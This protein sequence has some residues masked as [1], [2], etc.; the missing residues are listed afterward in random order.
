MAEK[1]VPTSD[2][3]AV[4][5]ATQGLWEE[6]RTGGCSSPAGRVSGEVAASF[7][8]SGESSAGVTGTSDGTHAKSYG[9]LRSRAAP[10]TG[11]C[12]YFVEW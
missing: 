2:L 6:M 12:D 4:L 3:D 11:R 10:S 9:V 1:P 5:E 7:R 8:S